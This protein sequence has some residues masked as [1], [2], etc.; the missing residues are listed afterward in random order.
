MIVGAIAS[1]IRLNLTPQ[2]QA[3]LAGARV[4]K[5]E[6]YEAY[7]QG[8]LDRAVSLLDEGV[9]LAR[10]AGDRSVLGYILDSRGV[11]AEACG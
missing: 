6:V 9:T 10:E 2:E 11:V 7:L 1:E 5:P 4:V 8:D 3:R